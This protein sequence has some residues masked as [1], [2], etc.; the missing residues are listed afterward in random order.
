MYFNI[1]SRIIIIRRN[2][3]LEVLLNKG[4]QMIMA[5]VFSSKIC[6]HKF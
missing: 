1:I 3:G 4:I 5:F 6:T 2:G